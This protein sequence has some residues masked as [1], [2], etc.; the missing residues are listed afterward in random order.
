MAYEKGFK[1]AEFADLQPGEFYKYLQACDRK[2][3]DSDYRA[4][5]FVSW[6]LAP[7]GNVDYK[8]IADPLW[9]G[10]RLMQEQDTVEMKRERET[11]IA[12]FGLE[13]GE[14]NG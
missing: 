8:K 12:E 9:E 5:Y 3:R 14:M 6:L 2:Q 10:K 4:A 7:Y 11:L 13:E 1:P